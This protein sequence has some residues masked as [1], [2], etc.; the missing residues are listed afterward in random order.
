MTL[1]DETPVIEAVSVAVIVWAPAVFSVAWKV[2]V[3]FVS[4]ELGDETNW[5]SLLERWTV[6]E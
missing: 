4:P 5:L 1:S 6:P 2:P 3:P